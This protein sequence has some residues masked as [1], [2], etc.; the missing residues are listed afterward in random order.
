[1]ADY[2]KGYPHLGK[3]SIN[4]KSMGFYWDT[5]LLKR[6]CIASSINHT[7]IKKRCLEL[8]NILKRGKK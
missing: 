3:K 1:M 8:V 7:T 2:S 6:L 4:R 5:A